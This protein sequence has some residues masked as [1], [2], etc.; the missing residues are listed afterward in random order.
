MGL[1]R[2]ADARA[3]NVCSCHSRRASGSSV[4]EIWPGGGDGEGGG[5]KNLLILNEILRVI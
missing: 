3:L 5:A 2:V 4:I 1:P